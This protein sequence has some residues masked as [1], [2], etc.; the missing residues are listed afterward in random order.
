M[1]AARP[2]TRWLTAVWQEYRST[3]KQRLRNLFEMSTEHQCCSLAHSFQ[4]C[5][6]K[7][8]VFKPNSSVSSVRN[9]L[10][11][12]SSPELEASASTSA[13]REQQSVAHDRGSRFETFLFRKSFCSSIQCCGRFLVIQRRRMKRRNPGMRAPQILC[14]PL[15]LALRLRGTT[16]WIVGARWRATPHTLRSTTF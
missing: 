5:T 15:E 7:R 3:Y 1:C 10:I 6:H 9:C 8:T 2:I 16:F 13:D 11:V 14:P 4:R 12:R